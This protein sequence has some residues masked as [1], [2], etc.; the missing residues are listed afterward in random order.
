MLIHPVYL[1]NGCGIINVDYIYESMKMFIVYDIDNWD[2]NW[3]E[4]VK[5]SPM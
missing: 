2:E 1:S 5:S 3:L 4:S